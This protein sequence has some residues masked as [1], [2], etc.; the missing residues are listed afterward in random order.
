MNATL[1]E[2]NTC[3]PE[4]VPQATLKLD[5][6]DDG[7]AVVVVQVHGEA[8]GDQIADL[9]KQLRCLRLGTQ[10]VILD[11]AE[12]TGVDRAALATLAEL[13]RDLSRKGGEVWL[14]GLRPAVWLALQ[15]A[16][17][18]R[19]FTIRATLAQALTS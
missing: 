19:L 16:G 18:A 13:S 3:L 9:D 17:L 8:T 12:L 10:F 4:S 2:R 15:V 7:D 6:E 14:T 1:L 11:L 5:I